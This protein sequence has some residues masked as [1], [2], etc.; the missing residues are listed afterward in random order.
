MFSRACF[1]TGEKDHTGLGALKLIG[2]GSGPSPS[3]PQPADHGFELK[4]GFTSL[5]ASLAS[6]A[7]GACILLSAWCYHYPK[8][9]QQSS[10][11]TRRVHQSSSRDQCPLHRGDLSPWLLTNSTSLSSLV[12]LSRVHH[13]RS[14]SATPLPFVSSSSLSSSPL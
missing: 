12:Y 5:E 6:L 4:P 7:V 1:F 2:F 3:V 13:C 11:A 14:R 8:R 9:V 10:M